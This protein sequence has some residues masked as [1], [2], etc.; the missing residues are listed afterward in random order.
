MPR[1]ER[2]CSRRISRRARSKAR[3]NG[4]RPAIKPARRACSIS[5]ELSGR[6]ISKC[7][8]S[9]SSLPEH[10]LIGLDALRLE[11]RVEARH[12]ARRREA[13]VLVRE[14][15]LGLERGVRDA[16]DLLDR[17][18]LD[19][20]VGVTRDVDDDLERARDADSLGP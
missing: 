18:D 5:Y 20:A 8:I 3:A 16:R 6:E 12:G 7:S 11:L 15:H 2:A 14:H 1:P 10:G 4:S 19:R 9:R 13:V 17:V